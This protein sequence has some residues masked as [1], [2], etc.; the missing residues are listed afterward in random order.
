MPSSSLTVPGNLQSPALSEQDIDSVVADVL[1]ATPV[2][3]MHT[4]LFPPSFRNIGCWG[5][6]DL[7]TYHYLEAE[8]F[9]SSPIETDH[10]FSLTTVEKADLIWRTLFLENTPVS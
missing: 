2:I 6:D 5:I 9:R 4:H 7:L 3:D 10:Y 8:L 1:K